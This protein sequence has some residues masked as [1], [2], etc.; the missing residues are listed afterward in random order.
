MMG[1]QIASE[2]LA[3]SPFF[4]GGKSWTPSHHEVAE[5]AYTIWEQEGRQS[6]TDKRDWE[7]ALALMNGR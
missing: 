7:R 4:C 6:G 5:F 1:N 2:L 3:K